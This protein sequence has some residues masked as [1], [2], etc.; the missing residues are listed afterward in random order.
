MG[1][2]GLWRESRICCDSINLVRQQLR[3]CHKGTI[4]TIMRQNVLLALASVWMLGVASADTV[5]SVPTLTAARVSPADNS[6]VPLTLDDDLGILFYSNLA[7]KV[8]VQV[9]LV[10]FALAFVSFFLSISIVLSFFQ[11]PPFFLSAFLLVPVF[12]SISSFSCPFFMLF[13][14][15]SFQYRC[16]PFYVLVLPFCIPVLPSVFLS[17]PHP[18][19]SQPLFVVFLHLSYPTSQGFLFS[20]STINSSSCSFPQKPAIDPNWSIRSWIAIIPSNSSCSDSLKIDLILQASSLGSRLVAAIFINPYGSRPSILSPIKNIPVYNAGNAT[21]SW[22]LARMSEANTENSRVY[23]KITAPPI[24][25]LDSS[26]LMQLTLG[27]VILVLAVSFL[28]SIFLHIRNSRTFGFLRRRGGSSQMPAQVL[29]YDS[30]GREV[31]DLAYVESLPIKTWKRTKD[32]KPG[33]KVRYLKD[34]PFDHD[35]KQAS[36]HSSQKISNIEVST[37]PVTETAINITNPEFSDQTL[38]RPVSTPSSSQSHLLISSS[39]VAINDPI[40]HKQDDERDGLIVQPSQ[41]PQSPTLHPLTARAVSSFSNQQSASEMLERR[42]SMAS[43]ISTTISAIGADTCAVC[44]EDYLDGDM[45]RE[46][47]CKHLFHSTC[48][49]KWLTS[50]SVQCPLCKQEAGPVAQSVQNIYINAFRYTYYDDNHTL[51]GDRSS[52]NTEENEQRPP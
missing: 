17:F 3:G 30:Q 47:P 35:K 18:S 40:H 25:S 4:D 43:V 26:T 52:L 12:L 39:T 28:V 7:L 23:L 22:F 37:T 20:L 8:D 51:N 41:Q 50:R 11:S 15:P 46:L 49:D 24:T 44:M 36:L 29:D 31:M 32:G 34:K 16:P 33:T 6:T 10:C 5:T 1:R 19:F 27:G 48:I 2:W 9:C 42:I 14:C 13:S 45:L 21:S 38:T